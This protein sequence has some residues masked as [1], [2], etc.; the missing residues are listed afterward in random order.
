MVDGELGSPLK[1]ASASSA[2]VTALHWMGSGPFELFGR[3]SEQGLKLP[4]QHCLFVHL[5]RGAAA[6][7]TEGGQHARRLADVPLH[8]VQAVAAIAVAAAGKTDYRPSAP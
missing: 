8:W 3:I 2:A 7:E 5:V 6:F 1:A 4:R